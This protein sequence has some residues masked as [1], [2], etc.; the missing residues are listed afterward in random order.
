MSMEFCGRCRGE[1]S[2][3]DDSSGGFSTCPECG[4]GGYVDEYYED[5]WY[6]DDETEYYYG[7]PQGK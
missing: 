2:A 3:Y 4:G 1:G 6:E 7:E 5:E